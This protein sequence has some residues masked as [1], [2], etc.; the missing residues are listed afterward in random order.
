[1]F[2]AKKHKCGN[3]HRLRTDY[4]LLI[5]VSTDRHSASPRG[6]RVRLS[7]VHWVPKVAVLRVVTQL[8]RTP[9]D[10]NDG[11]CPPYGQM[12]RRAGTAGTARRIFGADLCFSCQGETYLCEYADLGTGR[13]PLPI[14]RDALDFSGS[15]PWAPRRCGGR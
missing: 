2:T 8:H 15:H 13:R 11:Q 5:I 9:K 6:L 3:E 12:R 10:E 1:M 14:E 7:F 4:Y